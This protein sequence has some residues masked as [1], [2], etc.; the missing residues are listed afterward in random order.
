VAAVEEEKVHHQQ[1]QEIPEDLA[2]AELGM[3]EVLEEL[4]FLH[5]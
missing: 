2:A 5:H 3:E 1:D 4:V